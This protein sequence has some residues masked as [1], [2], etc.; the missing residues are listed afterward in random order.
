MPKG[1]ENHRDSVPIL[2]S[3]I[4]TRVWSET[5]PPPGRCLP[6]MSSATTAE[7]QSRWRWQLQQFPILPKTAARS[8]SGTSTHQWA[9]RHERLDPVRLISCELHQADPSDHQ[10]QPVTQ[11]S[12]PENR[13][14]H[15]FVGQSTAF[16][17]VICLRTERVIL[18]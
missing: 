3:K 5:S 16:S 12:R 2:E 13:Y 4:R 10:H 1:R 11:H 6:L 14:G 15:A 17:L 8:E 18:P 7:E 9:V